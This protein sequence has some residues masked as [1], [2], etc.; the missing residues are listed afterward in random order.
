MVDLAIGMGLPIFGMIIQYIPQGHRFN[1]FEDVGCY[2]FTWNTS[3]AYPLVFCPPVAI[4][5][6]SAYYASRSIY[7]FNKQRAMFNELL[8]SYSN[9]TSSRYVRLMCLA[10][11]EVLLTV[12]LGSY[13]I[14]LNVKTGIWKWESWADTH[15]GFSRV[16][17]ILAFQWRAD[18]INE[19]SIELTRWLCVLCAFI[20]FGYFGFADEARKHY[21]STF[22]SVAKRTGVN[23]LLRSFTSTSSSQT[24]TNSTSNGMHSKTTTS[25]GK[26]RP[27]APAMIHAD[28]LRHQPSSISSLTDVSFGDV[29]GFLS[30][31]KSAA[32]SRPTIVVPTLAY[33]G[34]KLSDAGGILADYK[35]SPYSP[36]S[37][38]GSSSASSILDSPVS[39]SAPSLRNE[40]TE[41]S[42]KAH[43]HD[44]V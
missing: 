37:T 13:S 21:R 15:S 24:F 33:D 31:E 39:S 25:G 34:L 36:M 3:V 2:P 40:P 42:E 14:Y 8:S 5:L 4:G 30:D 22:Q 19:V 23:T 20:F 26:I 32:P 43:T 16:D 27:V 12:P 41:K 10:G 28:F 11:T 9:L 38:S 7:A 17:Q 35:E 1:I 44:M 18:P 29:S 6:V